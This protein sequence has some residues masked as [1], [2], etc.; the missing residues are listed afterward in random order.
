MKHVALTM[1]F[2][3]CGGLTVGGLLGA[4]IVLALAATRLHG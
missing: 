1:A 4:F 3:L 2:L